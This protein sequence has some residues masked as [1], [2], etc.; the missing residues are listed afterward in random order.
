MVSN[1]KVHTA[2]GELSLEPML[3]DEVPV[4]VARFA[5][6]P[7]MDASAGAPSGKAVFHPNTREK[8]DRR[9]TVDRRQE[10]RFQE[11]R[12]AKGDRRPKASWEPGSN[13]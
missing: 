8:V 11:D 4:G 6:E 7:A 9:K 1:D 3:G 13:I 5:L 2:F 10:L 12:R